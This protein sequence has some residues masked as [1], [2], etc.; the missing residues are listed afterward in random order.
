MADPIIVTEGLTKDYRIGTH[1]V[2]ALRGVDLTVERGEFVAIMGPSGS[3]KST[4]MQLLGCLDTPTAGHYVL[5]GED[6]SRLDRDRLARTRNREIG[7]VFQSFNLLPR[8]T[9]LHNVELPLIYGRTPRRTRGERAAHALEAVGLA[10]RINH[11][12][13]QLSGGQMQRVAIARAMVNDPVLV[14]ADEPT[15]ALD[16]RTGIEIMTLFQALNER[17]NT[18]IVVT[19]EA[20]VARFARRVLRFRDG[21]LVADEPIRNPARASEALAALEAVAE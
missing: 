16:S 5:D 7:Y 10:D 2:H 8:L 12:P 15:G 13:T 3:G 14:L 19:H 17:G 6:V 11:L 21:L 9:A 20:D 18:I 1:V 4:C